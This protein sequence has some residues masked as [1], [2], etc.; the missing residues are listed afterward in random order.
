MSYKYYFVYS[1]LWVITA[2][3][4]NKDNSTG[5]LYNEMSQDAEHKK[6]VEQLYSQYQAENPDAQTY[7]KSVD[8][9]VDEFDES[10]MNLT[11]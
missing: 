5:H 9:I 10:M 2:L 7:I 6:D 1:A 11:N 4:D 3:V 8:E